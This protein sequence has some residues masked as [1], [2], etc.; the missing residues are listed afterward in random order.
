[1][2]FNFCCFLRPGYCS[3]KMVGDEEGGCL[4]LSR[5]ARPPWTGCRGSRQRF[6]HASRRR[7]SWSPRSESCAHWQTAWSLSPSSAT[8]AFG[9]FRG[10]GL[11]GS[12]SGSE[13]F[14]QKRASC[15]YYITIM[16]AFNLIKNWV[17][18][19]SSKEAKDVLYS[20][21][22]FILKIKNKRKK[23]WQHTQTTLLFQNNKLTWSDRGSVQSLGLARRW[24]GFYLGSSR[25]SCQPVPFYPLFSIKNFVKNVHEP[26]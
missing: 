10:T 7:S 15:Y 3:Y 23:V 5:S 13:T 12:R 26:E 11:L 24:L 18:L 17:R 19:A 1:M 21:C 20:W 14:R 4:Q 16:I 25:E 6:C 8:S 22:E 2:N 9:W